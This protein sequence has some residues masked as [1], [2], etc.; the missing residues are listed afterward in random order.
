VREQVF[1]VFFG[2]GREL[3]AFITAF[4]IPNL[5]RDLFAEGA[6]SAAF[7]TTFT[8]RLEHE[9][10][11]SAWRLANLVVNVLAL[12]VG[13]LTLLGIWLA[14]AL[15]DLI[16][17]GFGAIPG[18]VELTVGLTRIM[19]PFLFLI[20]LAAVA[21]G[22]L[23]TRNIF[24]VPASASAFF[25][26][27]SIVGGLGV[28]AWLAPDYL[29]GVLAHHGV[30]DPALA[31]RAMTGMAIGTLVGGFLQLVVQLPSLRRVG[32]RYR[33]LF[34]LR[35]PGVREVMRLMAPA[36]IGAAAVQVNVFVNN[37]FAS[38]L[39]NGPVSWLNVAFRFMQLP[40]GLFGV[41]IGTVTL[42]VVSRHGARGDAAAL[43]ATVRQAL[44]L[45]ALF[46][47]PAA[48]GLA[49]L[50]VPVIGIIYE[51]G[52]F[53]SADT[54]AAAQALAG[55]AIGLAGY[56]GIKVLAPTF[57]ALGD[58]RTPMA[59]SV[60]SIGVNYA[61]NWTFVRRLGFGHLGLALAT[62]AVALGNFALLHVFLRRRI[63]RFGG[64]SAV[65]RIALATVVMGAATWGVDSVLAAALPSAGTLRYAVRLLAVI[66]AAI[67]VFWAACRALGVPVPRL[68]SLRP[69]R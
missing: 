67:A 9:G 33:P 46:C 12:V 23:N 25:N 41:A 16:A 45:V 18:K 6:L 42:P 1:A 65:G 66:P 57:Y 39:G 15:V 11:R 3:D 31:A 20:A 64:R 54:V 14:P 60:L 29:R 34:S 52:R 30:G 26:L 5:L 35:D 13:L 44:D 19:F 28:A 53:T 63:G 36:T 56:A 47:M 58:A 51:H 40:I 37:N 21:M 22:V 55:Y 68:R 10:E 8:H 48:A 43:G 4:R 62:S 38:Y 24:G 7:V 2:A 59:V 50:G 61:L 69:G 27:G 17:P 32:F 49:L